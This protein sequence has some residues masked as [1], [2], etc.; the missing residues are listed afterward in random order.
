[1]RGRWESVAERADSLQEIRLRANRPAA[2][3]IDQKEWF[4]DETGRLVDM[5]PQTTCKPEELETV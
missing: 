3:L 5:P 2:V 1:M 4:V